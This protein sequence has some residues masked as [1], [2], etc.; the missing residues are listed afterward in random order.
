MIKN[1]PFLSLDS[2]NDLIKAEIKAAFERV[3]DKKW[4]VLGQE[5]QHF[6]NAYANFSN[7]NHCIGVANGLDA[8]QIAL[9]ALG[10]GPGDEVLAPTNTF[11]AT[12]LAISHCGATIVPV[13]PKIDTYNLDF[14]K[15][16]TLITDRTK[17]IIPVHL[18]GQICEMDQIMEIAKRYGLYII[19]DNAQAQ[20]AT[21]HGKISGS[22]GDLNCTSFYPTKNLG[23]FGDAGAIT[24]NDN[25]LANKT[26]LLRNYGSSEKYVNEQIGYNSRLDEMQAAFLSI[27]LKYISKWTIERQQIAAQ[28]NSGLAQIN[29]LVL[30][31]LA[32]GANH[33]YH[34]YVIRTMKRDELQQYLYAKGIGTGIHYPIPPHLQKAYAHLNYKKGDFPIVEELSETSLSLPLY[35]GMLAEDIEYVIKT[36]HSFYG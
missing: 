21:Y 3:F 16:E 7:T 8:L 24:T 5:V 20:G 23:A 2:Q 35:P 10:I 4:Y 29:Q 33:V 36:I 11:I 31:K 34:L 13:E 19:E 30:P 18:Y 14:N 28:Y 27:K 25:A 9:K 12:W 26:R 6:E 15:I 32:A 1:I 22:F 17:A